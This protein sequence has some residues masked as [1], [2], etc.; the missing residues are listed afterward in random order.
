[1]R[2]YCVLYSIIKGN[3]RLLFSVQP[4][5]NENCFRKSKNR[6]IRVFN[7][8]K[9]LQNSCLD[10]ETESSMKMR[11][12]NTLARFTEKR[13]GN[14]GRCIPEFQKRSAT[15]AWPTFSD[16]IS[17]Y[18]ENLGSSEVVAPATSRSS[19]NALHVVY[20]IPIFSVDHL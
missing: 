14:E 10:S 4:T 17:A 7:L 12:Q 18:E 16:S 19:C 13:I 2:A 8:N 3:E 5:Q 6:R 1:M 11:F 9:I 20:V 15:E